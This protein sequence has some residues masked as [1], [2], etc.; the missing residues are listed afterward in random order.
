MRLSLRQALNAGTEVA[1]T[2]RERP[3]HLGLWQRE[4]ESMADI[5]LQKQREQRGRGRPFEKGRSGNP[6]GRPRGSRDRATRSAELLLDGEAEALTRKAV[7]LAL[8]GDATALRLC[9]DRVIAPRRERPVQLALPPIRDAADVAEAMAAI[10]AAV[11][12][13]GIT[14]GEAAELAKL[15]D[16]FV[17]AIEA[18]DFDKRLTLLEVSLAAAS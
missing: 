18:S 11:A 3:K 8:C 17:R 16:T 10:T 4:V 6:A 13:G 7:A 12:R 15:I 9:L 2:I 1:G 14:P 5:P